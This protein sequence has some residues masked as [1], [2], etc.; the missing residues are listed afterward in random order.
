MS[1]RASKICPRCANVQPCP[2]HSSTPWG[3]STRRERTISG[4][5]Q[6]RRAKAVMHLHDGICHVCG[7]PGADQV[8][9]V[10][11]TEPE[12]RLPEHR[13]LPLSYVDS[14]D[15]L[16]PIHLRPCHTDKTQTEAARA[17]AAA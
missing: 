13:H 3:S 8:D 14:M 6:Q 9:H 5:K 7:R 16:R 4:S 2:T 10:I 12:A 15:N 1:Q 11:P 17:R